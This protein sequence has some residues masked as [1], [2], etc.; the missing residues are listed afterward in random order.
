MTKLRIAFACILAAAAWGCS[1]DDF[2]EAD[3]KDITEGSQTSLDAEQV[4]LNLGQ[5]QCGVE[6]A[7]WLPPEPVANRSVAR[8]LD[9]GRNLGFSDDVSIDE[10]GY[11]F[12]YAQVRG[13][14]PLDVGQVVNMKDGSEA[15]TKVVEVHVGV[16]IAHD[17]FQQSLPIIGIRKGRFVEGSQPILTFYHEGNNWHFD[18]FIH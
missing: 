12:P 3:V 10:A 18:K 11:M 6:N 7:L 16:K 14:L 9:N 15:G 4:S 2:F 13:K 17:C 8:L 5:V 1:H